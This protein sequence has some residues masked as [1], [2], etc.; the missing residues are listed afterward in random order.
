MLCPFG[1]ILRCSGESVS[2]AASFPDSSPHDGL[3]HPQSIYRYPQPQH[4]VDQQD[5][6]TMECQWH[7]RSRTNFA[8]FQLDTLER[9]FTCGHYPDSARVTELACLLGISEP[10]IQVALRCKFTDSCKICKSSIVLE[11]D[12]TVSKNKI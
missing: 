7:R 9:A 10:R 5:A 12:R 6:C 11:V 1:Y 4:H 2:V 3:Q 8:G